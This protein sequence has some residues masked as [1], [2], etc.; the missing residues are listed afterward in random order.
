[1]SKG[2]DT[3]RKAILKVLYDVHKNARSRKSNR[4]PVS[5]LKE[6]LKK[7]GFREQDI[8]S[9]LDYLIDAGWVKVEKDEYEFTTPKG[10]TRKQVKEYYKISDAGINYF[11]GPSEFQRIEKS[12]SGIKVKNIQ[13]ITIIGEVISSLTRSTWICSGA[14]RSY[15]KLLGLLI[16]LR[17]KKNSTT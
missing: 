8:V 10:F 15:R 13:G 11:E 5:E 7:L 12:I 6:E 1:M 17:M 16:S 3:C 2:S 14:C 9:E 4:A